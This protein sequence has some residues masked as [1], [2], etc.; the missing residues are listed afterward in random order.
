[1]TA[2]TVIVSVESA[3]GALAA[4]AAQARAQSVSATALRFGD[5][6]VGL[7]REG[8]VANGRVRGDTGRTV[9][10]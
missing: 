5:P 2:G 3:G 8:S 1:M 4:R 6:R 9:H 7:G 10:G